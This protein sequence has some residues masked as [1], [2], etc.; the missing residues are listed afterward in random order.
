MLLAAGLRAVVL[1]GKT[2]KKA[3]T[4]I[5]DGARQ[6]LVD[7]LVASTVFDEGIDIPRLSLVALAFPAKHAGR[8][9][10]RIGRALRIHEMKPAPVVLDFVDVN[11]GPLK[12]QART[13]ARV[14]AEQWGHAA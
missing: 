9:T 5:L 13:R 6:G 14:F 11:V 2:P 3:R 8:I 4:A 1:T 12:W 10:Q 7:V